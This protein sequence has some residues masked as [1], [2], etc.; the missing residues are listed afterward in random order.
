MV[1]VDAFTFYAFWCQKQDPPLQQFK[2]HF[3][4]DRGVPLFF[5]W[6]AVKSAPSMP[7]AVW[8][9]I[10]RRREEAEAEKARIEEEER[11]AERWENEKKERKELQKQR[12]LQVS[13]SAFFSNIS[14]KN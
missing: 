8:E 3:L 6:W 12:K 7:S 14:K 9:E 13:Q 5:S 2:A 4:T 10:K 11:E 1:E